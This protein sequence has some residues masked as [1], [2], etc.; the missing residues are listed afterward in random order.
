MKME[1]IILMIDLRG[2]NHSPYSIQAAIDEVKA[3]LRM[4]GMELSREDVKLLMSYRRGEI[5]GDELR[6]QIMSKV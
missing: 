4:E 2:I 5:T 6:A 1:S 3:T